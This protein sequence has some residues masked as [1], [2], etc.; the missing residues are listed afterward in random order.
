MTSSLEEARESARDHQSRADRAEASLKQLREETKDYAQIKR[1]RNHYRERSNELEEEVNHLKNRL[2]SAEDNCEQLR[3][4][5]EQ[6][7]SEKTQL[8]NE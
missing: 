2:A 3:D 1:D 4:E 7:H 8:E 6:A 5:L